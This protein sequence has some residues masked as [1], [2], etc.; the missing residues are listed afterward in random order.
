MNDRVDFL[1]RNR[2]GRRDKGNP[3][4]A[5]ERFWLHKSRTYSMPTHLSESMEHHASQTTLDVIEAFLGHLT[6]LSGL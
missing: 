2:S 1:G 6:P 3:I 5:L 4:S